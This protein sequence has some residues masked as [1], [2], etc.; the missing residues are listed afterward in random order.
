[1]SSAD[2]GGHAARFK[3]GTKVVAG[4]G[5]CGE[6]AA[7]IIE[8]VGRKLAHLVVKPKH[9][10]GMGHLVPIELVEAGGDPIRLSCTT[11]EFQQL[12]D[13]QE[14]HFLEAS[15]DTW[16]YG[17]AYSWPNY[18]LGMVGG[19]GAGGMGD[20]GLGHHS[21]PQPIATDRIPVGEVEVRRGDPVHASDGWIGSVK[22]LVVDPADSHVTHALL[23]EGHLWGRKQVAI[24]IGTTSRID[25]VIRVELTKQQIENLPPV[26]SG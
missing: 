13:A 23:E 7:V 14:I 26:G 20:M 9:H 1:M 8:P 21:T 18:N 22:G 12:D 10:G 4:D 3:I 16:S 24:P 17:Q 15:D 19:M 6:L 11:A 5:T 25:D 2:S